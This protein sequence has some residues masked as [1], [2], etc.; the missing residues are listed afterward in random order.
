M[1]F[2]YW[3]T[4]QRRDGLRLFF[5]SIR[6][7][8]QWTIY[9]ETFFDAAGLIIDRRRAFGESLSPSTFKLPGSVWDV[10]GL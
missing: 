1:Q 4:D 6:L 10:L 5:P 9:E 2:F 3:A 7:K 8:T